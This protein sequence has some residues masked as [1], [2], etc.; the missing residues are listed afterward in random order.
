[1]YFWSIC[2]LAVYVLNSRSSSK[3]VKRQQT[4]RQE[5]QRKASAALT[6]QIFALPAWAEF[7]FM[8]IATGQI[9]G[10]TAAAK[11]NE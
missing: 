11:T 10:P 9:T 7:P 2:Y 1:M 6:A 3:Q 8:A 5:N 4:S